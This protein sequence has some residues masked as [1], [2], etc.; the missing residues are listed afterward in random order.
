MRPAADLERRMLVLVFATDFVGVVFFAAF[1]GIFL[2][3]FLA[4]FLA[5][6]FAA[7][8]AVGRAADFFFAAF[9]AAAGSAAAGEPSDRKRVV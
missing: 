9:L 7:F 2:A 6:F 8:P 1:A 4:A 5:T 3:A